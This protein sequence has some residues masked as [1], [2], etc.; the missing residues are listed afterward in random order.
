MVL[1]WLRFLFRIKVIPRQS[2]GVLLDDGGSGGGQAAEGEAGHGE[3]ER[4]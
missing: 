1:H 4:G 3:T 2:E